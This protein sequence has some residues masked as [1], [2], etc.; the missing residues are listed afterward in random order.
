MIY[1]VA[2]PIGKTP[3]G[4]SLY[5]HYVTSDNEFV[6]LLEVTE[7]NELINF[8]DPNSI[9]IIDSLLLE[10]Y[11]KSH[12]HKNYKTLGLIHLPTFFDN[13]E[14]NKQEIIYYQT[15][16]LLVT[17]NSFKLDLVQNY[18]LK[19]DN[20]T[21]ITPGMLKVIKKK[22]FNSQVKNIVLVGS[23][24]RRK[25]IL[26]FLNVMNDL[27]NYPWKIHIY[28]PA[29]DSDYYQ[30][31]QL[32]I[33]DANL[34]DRVIFHNYLAHSKLLK[35]LSNFDLFINFSVYE[36]F[37]MAIYEALQIGLPVLS[38]K[39]NLEGA[40]T[41]RPHFKNVDSIATF[42]SELV[43]LLTGEKAVEIHHDKKEFSFRSWTS[44][45]EEFNIALKHILIKMN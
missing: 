45:K 34:K 33:V 10:A 4:G 31:L 8:I 41:K 19:S 35:T 1:L 40:F 12:L 26:E 42:K 25:G 6:T 43:G 44:V 28:G 5:N 14:K 13:P 16:P 20:I 30:E 21:T 9:V 3:T 24:T 7:V 29:T 23:I 15:I 37:G 18:N 39:T 22:K 27:L 17:G 11:F 38:Y 36:T 2:P 32:F